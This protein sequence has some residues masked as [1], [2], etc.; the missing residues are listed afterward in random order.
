MYA[1]TNTHIHMYIY[2]YTYTYTFTQPQV[3]R[4]NPESA[5]DSQDSERLLC[6]GGHGS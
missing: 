2:V 3:N 5:G 1:Y 4:D 6:G